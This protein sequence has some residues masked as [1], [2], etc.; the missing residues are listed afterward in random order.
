[1]DFFL[2]FFF[3]FL[4]IKI[5]GDF[6]WDIYRIQMNYKEEIEKVNPPLSQDEFLKEKE[7]KNKIKKYYYSFDEE[8]K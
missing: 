4:K 8:P 2:I 5:I 7:G 1:M 6:E 3:F